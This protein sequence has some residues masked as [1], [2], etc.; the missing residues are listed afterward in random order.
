MF[1]HHC[2]HSR[3]RP[4][5]D[6]SLFVFSCLSFSFCFLK[7][8]A[9]IPVETVIEE[10]GLLDS[11]AVEKMADILQIDESRMTT[12]IGG[13]QRSRRSSGYAS[14]SSSPSTIKRVTEP[15]S[16]IAVA[17]NGGHLAV[18]ED[19]SL[20]NEDFK[21]SSL[22]E[23]TLRWMF[24]ADSSDHQQS[25]IE[26]GEKENKINNSV[27]DDSGITSSIG[28]VVQ[29]TSEDLITNLSSTES[30]PLETIRIY[31]HFF[32]RQKNKLPSF[33]DFRPTPLTDDANADNPNNV[34]SEQ[35]QM[36]TLVFQDG[37][38]ALETSFPR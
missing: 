17:T 25:F 1:A 5:S 12:G 8:A 30:A 11:N 19:S 23:V 34:S 20:T 7:S 9:S 24:D 29:P 6:N 26:E 13:G 14:A 4:C 27:L 33:I 31:L 16:T 18:P 22:Y 3:K 15:P 37:S 35:R 28:E 32:C 36:Y 10:D 21:I 38:L 2:D